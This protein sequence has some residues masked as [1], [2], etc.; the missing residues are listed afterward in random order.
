MPRTPAEYS[1]YFNK[2]SVGQ[3]NRDDMTRYEEAYVNIPDRAQGY[4]K[5]V[6]AEHAKH[7]RKK[8]YVLF[9]IFL[10]R[11]TSWILQPIHD[12]NT[13]AG[14]GRHEAESPNPYWK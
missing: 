7:T 6:L 13:Y 14:S 8:S 5:S 10:L 12:L 9:V 1:D 2:S 4:R 11:L 3:L